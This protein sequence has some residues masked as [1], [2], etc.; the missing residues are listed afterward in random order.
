M[1][2]RSGG[3]LPGD[4]DVGMSRS[5]DGGRTWEPM[6]VIM[7]M[8]DDPKWRYDGI[9]DPAVLVDSNTGTIW[10]A[11]TWSHGNRSWVGSRPGLQPEETGQLMLLRS[12]DDGA[13]WS[14][15]I[16]ITKQVKKPEWCFILQGP[17]KGITMRDGTIVFAAQYQDPPNAADKRAHRLPHSTIIYSKDHGMTWQAG[18]GAFADTTEAQV[19]EVQPGVLMLNCRYNRKSARVV[20]TTRDMGKTWNQHTTSERSL[21]EPGACMASLIDVDQEV[22][23]DLGGWLLFSNPDSL[24]G[25]NHITIKASPDRGQTWPKQHRLLLDEENS[26]GYSCMSM[27]DA[28]TVGIL[29]EGSQA[30]MT[31]Q[32]IPLKDVLGEVKEVGDEQTGQGDAKP[33]T[34]LALES[35]KQ[36]LTLPQVFGSHMV[37]QADA[38]MPIWGKAAAGASVSVTLGREY[39]FAEADEQGRWS[40]R[41]SPRSYASSPI[42][43]TVRSGNEQ[44]EFSDVLIGEVWLC[45]G[46]SNM[47]WPLVQSAGGAKE[48]QRL[49]KTDAAGLRLLHLVAGARGSSGSYSSEDLDRLEPDAY[50]Q[51]SWKVASSESAQEFSAVA[52]Y[53]G[54]YLQEQLDVPVG[55]ICPAVGGTPAESWIPRDA[56]QADPKLT[57]MV[58]GNWLDNPRLGEF[59]KTRGEQN[60]LKALQSGEEIPGDE[61]GLNHSFKPGF[62]WDAGIKPL[63]PYAIRGAIWYQG[64]SNAETPQR[65]RQ[66]TRLLPLLI[67]QWRAGWGQGDFPFLFVQLPAINRT[68]W[69]FFRE[70]QRWALKQAENLGMAITIDTGD[71]ANVHP[72]WKR[73]VGER[74]ARWALGTTYRSKEHA[75]YSGPL[76]DGFTRKGSSLF[77]RFKHAGGGLK[78]SDAEPLRHFEICGAD[79]VFHPANAELRGKDTVEVSAAAVSEPQHVRYAWLSFPNPSV[80]LFNSEDLPASPF[81]TETEEELFARQFAAANMDRPNVLFIVSEDNSPHLGCYGEQRVHTPNLD[82]LAKDGIRYTRA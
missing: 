3:D 13:T 79:G 28:E 82:A 35:S 7:D 42:A 57:G 47:Q 60:L 64:E 15:P 18:T 66:H 38:E 39:R 10:V 58:A 48:L 49:A 24:R 33:D 22:G 46:Q 20:M 27:I 12:D 8:G 54:R 53:F 11:A 72:T 29:Y 44:I 45:A 73:P 9:G 77:V 25:R 80:N 21:I 67:Q 17:G 75:C 74:L 32:R 81:S 65:V 63:I 56:L 16:N 31:F 43:L 30:H 70:T 14:K 26:A 19:V 37:L 55:L 4:I 50:C 52:W 36:Q 71:P 59:C 5:T 1:R 61:F 40:V 51:G 41:M 6:D 2:R 68:E 23:K 62:M 69:P 34:P 76:L 78:S